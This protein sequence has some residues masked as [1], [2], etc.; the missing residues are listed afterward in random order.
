MPFQGSNRFNADNGNR[1]GNPNPDM[2]GG[3]SFSQRASFGSE[4]DPTGTA[5]QQV[6]SNSPAGNP[7]SSAGFK[8]ALMKTARSGSKLAGQMPN[9]T[10]FGAKGFKKPNYFA[11]GGGRHGMHIGAGAPAISP[12]EG[13][14]SDTG[15]GSF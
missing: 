7:H 6:L 4:Q 3:A 1:G 15:G 9:K 13:T 2:T 11:Q 8:R 12:A 14:G 10:S 5:G